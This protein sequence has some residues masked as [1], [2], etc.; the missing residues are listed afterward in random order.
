MNE[1]ND[2]IIRSLRS[3][4]MER[5]PIGGKRSASVLIP[6]IRTGKR[7][8]SQGA[9]HTDNKPEAAHAGSKPD[10]VHTGSKQE[11][12]HAG[13]MPEAAQ[14]DSMPDVVRKGR[15]Q[16]A[17]VSNT[18][19]NS[20]CK[21]TPRSAT[22]WKEEDHLDEWGL[23]FE[24]RSGNIVQGGEI[25]FP[26]GGVE[27]GESAEEAAV[28]ETMEE[29]LIERDQLELICPMFELTGPAGTEVSSYL[30]VLNGYNG[31]FSMDEV[32]RIFTLPL[33][34]FA[35]HPAKEYKASLETK[36]PEN[37]PYDELPGGKQY[38]FRPV[39]KTFYFY[40]TDYGPLW[41]MT[42]Q[43]VHAVLPLLSDM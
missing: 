19:Q 30:G 40:E 24:V 28:R 43:I 21:N 13:S 25:C 12:A 32:S 33:S 18:V 10:A 42:A 16:K 38:P 41:G 7:D 23:L 14:T 5:L 2:N 20:S 22:E 36:L 9:S 4:Q 3:H 11:A 8:T 31:T 17:F 27:P 37:F 6:L 39:P 35:A 15:L 1:N 26:G 29:L 34:W